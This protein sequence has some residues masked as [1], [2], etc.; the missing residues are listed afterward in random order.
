MKKQLFLLIATALTLLAACHK[1]VVDVRDF[2]KITIDSISPGTGP[3]GMY[4]IVYGNNFSYQPSEVTAHI[5]NTKV[6]VIE[7]APRR[8]MIYIPE[9]AASGKLHFTFNRQNP[10]NEQ[11]NYAGQMDT[12]ADGPGYIINESIIPAPIIEQIVPGQGRAGDTITINGYNFS[13]G[14]CKVLF[15]TDEGIITQSTPTQLKVKIPKTTP[16]TVALIIQQGTHTVTAGNFVVEETPA[17]VKEI[18]W[19]ASNGTVNSIG[20]AVIDE[21]GNAAIQELY[22][23]ADGISN[24]SLGVKADV[25]NG[26]VYWVD[27]NTIYRGSTDGTAPMTLIYTDPGPLIADIDLDRNGKLYLT[28]WSST[29]AGHHAIKKI[30]ADGTGPVEELYQLPG[31]PSPVGMKVDVATGK[32]YWAE[33]NTNQV[34][35]GSI[36]GQAAQPARVLFDATDGLAAVTNIAVSLTDGHIYMADAGVNLIYSG[37]LDGS[38]S[39][40]ALPIPGTDLSGPLDLEIDPVNHFVYWQFTHDTNGA[41]M[42]YK[43]D[44]TGSAQRVV[45][46]IKNGFFFDL[47]L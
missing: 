8:M 1:E 10:T 41:I 46:N 38:G 6:Q 13:E 18:Y 11:F 27:N 45:N 20:K 39:L 24:S 15:G 9:G 37:A 19:A 34:M 28:G 7:I 17:G 14:N 16:G 12:V 35:E 32:I 43:T 21:F 4:I 44:G 23:T 40:T 33:M 42:R 47:V 22:G 26:F 2:G 36:N 29:L 25:A 3:S 31:E 5:N 30:N